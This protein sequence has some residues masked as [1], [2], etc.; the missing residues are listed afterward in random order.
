[1]ASSSDYTNLIPSEN[2]SKPK[3]SAMVSAVTQC[4]ADAINESQAIKAS[5]DLDTATGA[6]L[7][8]VG[9]WVGASRYVS[10][11]LSGIYFALD[12]VGL[13][14]DQ[15]T[16]QGPYDPSE[17]LQT[18]DDETYRTFIRAKIGANHWDGTM[19][20]YLSILSQVFAGSGSLIF[21]SDNQDMSM[22]V[23]VAGAMPAAVLRQ[24]LK[25]GYLAIKPSGVHINGFSI[26]SVAGAPLFGFDVTNSYVAGFDAGA[27]ATSI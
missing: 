7:D 6:Q 9:L 15:G 18:L 21:A 20:G 24:L 3:F 11:P 27:W 13:G 16:W 17:G 12:T 8:A 1:M 4:F 22:D 25:S 19:P 26:S 10:T 2:A 14:F 5:F 23:Y